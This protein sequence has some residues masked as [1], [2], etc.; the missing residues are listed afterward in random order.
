M[1][2]YFYLHLNLVRKVAIMAWYDSVSMVWLGFH[3][4]TPF[5]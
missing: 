1:I 5:P 4:L 3:G 2:E